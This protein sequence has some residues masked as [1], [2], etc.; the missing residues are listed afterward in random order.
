M[1]FALAKLNKRSGG[2][3]RGNVQAR[4]HARRL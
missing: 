4:D 3:E 1:R 2:S